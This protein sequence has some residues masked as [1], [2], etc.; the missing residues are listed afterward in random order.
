MVSQ[1]KIQSKNAIGMNSLKVYGIP[2]PLFALFAVAV[3]AASLTD[4]LPGNIVGALGITLVLGVIFGE[5][6]DRIPI[7]N[8]YVGGGA[9]LAFLGSA[10]L[11][12][13]GI[14]P[15]KTIETIS[16][17]IE[18]ANFLNL[19][20]S[21]L[22]TGSILSV[23]R[24]LLVKALAGYI[25]TIIFGV[26]G[27]ML[28]GTIG[29]LITGI[30]AKDVITMYVLPIMGGG[31]GAGALPMSEIYA[32]TTG[33]DPST[34]LSFAF[35]ILTIANIVAIIVAALL[36]KLG[37]KRSELTGNGELV[38]SKS[39]D[40]KEAKVDVKVTNHE[41]GAG[42]LLSTGFFILAT[43][44]SRKL[45]PTIFGVQIHTFA[46]MVL[47]VSLFNGLNLIPEELKQGAKKLQS[48]F[49]GRFLWVIMIGV[50]VAYTD[51]AEIIAALTLQN[52]IVATFIV[53]GA[54]V[55]TAVFGYLVGFFP[56]E[57]AITAG[58]CMANRG[59]SGDLAVLGAAKRM[60]LISWAQIS[61]RL[62]GGIML[63]IA[64]IVFGL[65]Y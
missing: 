39:E 40:A 15:E 28:L 25:P 34:F 37:E 13:A 27:A 62:G 47:F 20:I 36:N 51:L 9:I 42:L 49:S 35:P 57:S 18:S 29:G 12:Y 50:G 7:W 4:V 65:F 6:G 60:D 52:V 17:F 44:V 41:L 32:S 43:L 58:L 38:R 56:I 31:T 10:Y 64:S 45:L 5:I 8:E 21:V 63:V 22:I 30:S 54:T 1:E 3:I 26:L 24:K 55:G 16:D 33:N 61:S 48:F 46:Y 2:L 19:F 14:M 53:V 11:V 23:N 59:G